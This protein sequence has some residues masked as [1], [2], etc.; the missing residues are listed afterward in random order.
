MNNNFIN[1]L[2]FCWWPYNS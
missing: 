1:T 2:L